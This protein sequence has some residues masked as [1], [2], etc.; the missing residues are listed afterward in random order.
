MDTEDVGTLLSHQLHTPLSAIKWMSE[1]LID[2]DL[3][4]L[5]PTQHSYLEQIQ[6]NQQ[7][8]TI[9]VHELVEN[10]RKQPT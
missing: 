5:T 10:L 2:R 1:M 8:L 9:M 4:E 3:G 7:Q 6:S